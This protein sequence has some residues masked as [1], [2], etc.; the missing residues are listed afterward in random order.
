MKLIL[1]LCLCCFFEQEI[2]AQTTPLIRSTTGVAGGSEVVSNGESSYL[3]QQSFGQQSVIGTQGANN[4]TLRQGFIQPNILSLIK[5]KELPVS[6]K[7][8]VY[9]TPFDE[10]IT[11]AF[12]EDIKSEVKVSIFN[13]LGAQVFAIDC[14]P[15]QKISIKLN[16]LPSGQYFLKAIT[17]KKQFLR[18]VLKK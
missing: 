2:L 7:M 9:P 3:I 18:K 13:V 14:K 15:K 8:M 11:L 5:D 4:Y 10:Q 16:Q 12:N 17:N 6:F 1:I